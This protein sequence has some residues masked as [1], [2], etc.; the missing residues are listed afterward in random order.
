MLTSWRGRA[1]ATV[2]DD[3]LGVGGGSPRSSNGIPLAL[4]VIWWCLANRPS[5]PLSMRSVTLSLA[6]PAHYPTLRPTS[7]S[8]RRPALALASRRPVAGGCTSPGTCPQQHR[9]HH[10]AANRCSDAIRLALSRRRSGHGQARVLDDGRAHDLSFPAGGRPVSY[11]HGPGQRPASPSTHRTS[12]PD[13]LQVTLSA[14]LVTTSWRQSGR[15]VLLGGS[16][17]DTIRAATRHRRS[18]WRLGGGRPEKFRR[19]SLAAPTRCCSTAS[20]TSLRS[21]QP[22]REAIARLT[23]DLGTIVTEAWAAEPSTSG[24][25]RRRTTP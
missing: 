8:A 3:V 21:S 17:N 20:G 15:Q 19:R 23:R 22:L 24:G 11:E 18:S 4:K 12:L 25:F 7:R 14:A 1:A 9:D 13:A 16:G 10:P 2:G 6:H 5:A